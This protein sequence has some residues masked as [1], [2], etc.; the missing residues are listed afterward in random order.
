MYEKIIVVTRKTRLQELVAKFNTRRQAKFYIEHGGG[1]FV[2]YE[3]EDDNYKRSLDT[4]RSQVGDQLKVQYIDREFLPNFIFTPKDVILA[5]GQDGLVANAAKYVGEQPIVG[6]NPDP[7]RFDG[8][9]VPHKTSS[10]RSAMDALLASKAKFKRVSLAE[11]SLNDGQRLLAFNDLFVGA[12]T[13]VSARYRLKF[14]DRQEIQSSSGLIISTGAGATGWL[15]SVFN[16]VASI[17]SFTDSFIQYDPSTGRV[18]RPEMLRE[19]YMKN[20]QTQW[21]SDE[22]WFVVREPFVS[23]HSSAEIVIGRLPAGSEL[24]IESR[25]PAGG[26]IFSDGIENDFLSFDSGMI[27]K[28]RTAEQQAKLMLPLQ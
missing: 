25:M 17:G 20:M 28:V 10:V 18:V 6:V 11:A 24:T 23:R 2:D 9:L 1:D 26:T 5:L 4:V 16:M 12:K 27:A 8:I 13:H 7:S 22:L 14:G 21:R 3:N 19:T 15:S